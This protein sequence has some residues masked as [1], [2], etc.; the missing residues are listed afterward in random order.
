MRKTLLG[1]V[2]ALMM[3]LSSVGAVSADGT[4]TGDIPGNDVPGGFALVGWDGGT[5]DQL[6]TAAAQADC[7]LR[8]ASATVEGRLVTYIVG[9][10]EFVN[11]EWAT[12]LGTVTLPRPRLIQC[13]TPDLDSCPASGSILDYTTEAVGVADPWEALAIGVG[14][15]SQYPDGAPPE[16]EFVEASVTPGSAQSDPTV[17]FELVS[18]DGVVVGRYTVVDYGTGWLLSGT[19]VCSFPGAS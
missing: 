16:G 2:G 13:Y 19:H 7:R 4:L 10:P 3:L 11:A 12:T 17:V 8:T 1:V 15:L 14:V 18:P 5:V 9:A 6:V